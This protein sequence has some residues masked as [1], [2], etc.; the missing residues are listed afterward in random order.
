MT[1][2]VLRVTCDP[3]RART[4]D[5]LLDREVFYATEL[6]GHGH[7]G[8]IQDGHPHLRV[9]TDNTRGFIPWQLALELPQATEPATW[10]G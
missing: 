7:P 6:Q 9:L 10:S 1:D 3:D 8:C 4:G 5:I 2:T